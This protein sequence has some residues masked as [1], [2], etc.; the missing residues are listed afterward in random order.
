MIRST[1]TILILLSIATVVPQEERFSKNIVVVVDVSGS[2]N[3]SI[4]ESIRSFREVSRQPVDEM[5]LSVVA[6]AS[7]TAFWDWRKL[8]D[9]RA[10][11]DAEAWLEMARTRL[12]LNTKPIQAF[13][14]A[15]ALDKEELSVVLVSDGEFW[16]PP[17]NVIVAAI[18]RFQKE[19]EAA[20][21]RSAVICCIGVDAREKESLAAI[22]KL[23]KGGYFR[24]V[25]N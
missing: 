25:K 18:K 19:R 16:S 7:E 9:Q 14:R 15:L 13:E 4:E 1:A 22:A 5:N 17:P 24:W 23:G 2:M 10:V 20:G 11:D 12:G 6:F 8:P 3:T 21:K